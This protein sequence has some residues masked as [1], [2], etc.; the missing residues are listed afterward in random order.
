MGLY[1][2]YDKVS[3]RWHVAEAIVRP[4]KVPF[5]IQYF[6]TLQLAHYSS[7]RLR[8]TVVSKPAHRVVVLMYF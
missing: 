6:Q 5:D 7:Y 3:C 2:E 4:F 1:T 8:I